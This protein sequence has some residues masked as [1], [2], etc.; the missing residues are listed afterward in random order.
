M[1]SPESFLPGRVFIMDN[2]SICFRLLKPGDKDLWTDFVNRCSQES[3][4]LRFLSPFHPTPERAHRFCDINPEQECAIIAETTEGD[5]RKVVGIARLIRLT[6]RDEA[7]YSVIISDIWQRKTLGFMLSE[8]SIN[9]ARHWGVN[10]ITA[11]TIHENH[12]IIKILKRFRFKV[13]GKCGNMV[14]LSLKFPIQSE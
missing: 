13:S 5:C 2:L 8:M 10:L 3:L 6:A 4:W 11:E 7:E 12:P 1:K 9:L 14:S